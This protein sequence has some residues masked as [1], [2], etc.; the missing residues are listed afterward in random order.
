[1]DFWLTPDPNL[2]LMGYTFHGPF[3]ETTYNSKLH[4]S[5]TVDYDY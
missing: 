2:N 5:N 4:H 3:C 1:M